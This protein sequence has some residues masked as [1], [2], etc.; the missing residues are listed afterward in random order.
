MGLFND[1]VTKVSGFAKSLFGSSSAEA[2]ETAQPAAAASVAQVDV[3]AV[4]KELAAKAGQPLNYKESIV[5]LLKL[6]GLDSSLKARQ[7]LADEL[8]YTGDKNDTAT[9]NVWLIKQ[10]YTELA[11]NGGKIPAGWGH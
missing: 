8:H 2:A 3:D 5:D 7:T 1:I 6:L 9:M 10:V 11:N 4:L